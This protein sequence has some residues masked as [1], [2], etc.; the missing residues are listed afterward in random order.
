MLAL[1]REKGV[2][3]APTPRR[4]T[5]I[6]MF[7]ARSGSPEPRA[8]HHSTPQLLPKAPSAPA[9][10]PS[11]DPSLDH[12]QR[13][14]SVHSG[15]STGEGYRKDDC[16]HHVTSM[17]QPPGVCRICFSPLW[18]KP[19]RDL[20]VSPIPRGPPFQDSSLLYPNWLAVPL[21]TPSHLIQPE[22]ELDIYFWVQPGQS[23]VKLV[24][25]LSSLMLQ[26]Q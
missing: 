19:C 23:R 20:Q 1:P 16:L 4:R 3:V 15:P 5:E 8:P 24:S 14:S 17:S 13:M 22:P 9:V 11:L 10:Q 12:P 26:I 21:N 7:S 25:L 2:P 18:E 6:P